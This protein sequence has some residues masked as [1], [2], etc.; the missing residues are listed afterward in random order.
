MNSR[1]NSI[2]R[3][4]KVLGSLEHYL[5]LKS[6]QNLNDAAGLAED[7]CVPLLNLVYGYDLKNVN[8]EVCNAAGID[9]L[10]RGHRLAVQ[11]TVNDTTEKI[12]ETHRGVTK[13][14][15]AKEFDKVIIF[16]LVR[17]APAEPESSSK[18]TPCTSHCI[19]SLDLDSLLSEIRGLEVDKQEAVADLLEKEWG[20]PQYQ[21]NRDTRISNLPF[22]PLG[23]LFI[24]REVFLGKLRQALGDGKPAVIKSVQAIHGMGGVGK[25]RA[26]IEYAWQHQND[27]QALLFVSADSPEALHRNLAT[28]CGLEILNLPEQAASETEVQVNAVLKWLRENHGWFLIIDNADTRDT[29]AAIRKLATPL[30]HGHL[31]VTSRLADWPTGFSTLELDV[32]SP[33]D[34]VKLLLDHT[35]GCRRLEPDEATAA[36]EIARLVDGLALALEQAAA[37]IRETRCSFS[38]YLEKWQQA[39]TNLHQEYQIKG[40]DDYHRQHPKLPR[41]LWVTFDT[42]FSQLTHE[43]RQLLNILSW[44]SPEP[45]PVNALDQ[46]K[47]IPDAADTLAKL[48]ALHLIRRAADGQS[49]TVHRLIQEIVRRQQQPKSESLMQALVW[50]NNLYPDDSDDV[51]NWDRLVPLISHAI[52]TATFADDR[53]IANPTSRLFNQVSLLLGACANYHSAERLIRRALNIDEQN[54]G[55]LHHIIAIGLNN[56]AQLLKTTGRFGEAEQLMRRALYINEQCFGSNDLSVAINLNNLAALYLATNRL[57]EA[58][59]LF[60]RAL[61]IYEHSEPNH[62]NATACLSN[63]AQIFQATNRLAQAE[64]FLRSSLIIHEKKFEKNHPTIATS[65]NNL[66]SLLQATNRTTEAEPLMRRAIAIDEQCFGQDHPTVATDLNNLAQ[67]LSINKRFA[68]AEP[69]MR[70]ALVIDEKKLGPNHPSVATDL[71]NLAQLLKETNR[72]I[73]AESLMRQALTIYEQNPELDHTDVAIVLNNLASLLKATN[74]LAEAEPLMRRNVEILLKFSATTGHPHPYLQVG[75]SNYYGLLM[76]MGHTEE[77]VRQKISALLA[78]HGIAKDRIA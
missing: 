50:V 60:Q 61:A 64:L 75:L 2:D 58:E 77:Q 74:R 12:R 1:L 73:E 48:D 29:Q 25:T 63:L 11:V 44:L 19:T 55:P 49:F 16:F 43:A 18:F 67:L 30:R 17:K 15:L 78:A 10:D 24:G 54:F 3:I 20:N 40:V 59:S 21:W 41:S 7:F 65:L 5:K 4:A 56:L 8:L 47:A 34:S 69:L 36:A 66:A 9:L 72:L 28:L 45:M 32:L 23:P 57:N 62:P 27:Y 39:E 37:F 31:I 76:A 71:N 46:L 42:S 53:N 33:D 38:R 52:A 14:S 35:A 26:A 22:D 13:S 68:E 70:Q 6:G 51:R